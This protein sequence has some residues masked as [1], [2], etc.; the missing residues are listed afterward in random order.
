HKGWQPGKVDP[1]GFDMDAVRDGIGVRL[2]SKP[3]ERPAFPGRDAFG[4]GKSN[5]SIKL[6][7]Q[8]LIRRGYGKHYRVGPSKSWDEADRLNVRDFQRSNKQ[9]SGGAD[10]H[11]GPLTWH[12]LFS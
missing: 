1:G 7:G 3:P 5:A 11:P 6:L 8:Q 2:G 10:G 4:P 12:L 9:L